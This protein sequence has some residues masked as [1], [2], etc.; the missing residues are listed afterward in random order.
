MV[1]LHFSRTPAITHLKIM[2]LPHRSSHC[3]SVSAYSPPP[4]ELTDPCEYLG[5]KKRKPSY[6]VRK[7]EGKNLKDELLQL[8]AQVAVLKTR[9]MP[10]GS[11]LAADPGLQQSKAKSKA[12]ADSAKQQGLRIA[13]AQS[14]M[15]ECVRA[16]YSNPLCTRICLV[17]DKNERRAVLKAIR[18]EKLKNAYDY[19]MA[20]G[21]HTP[22]GQGKDTS[23]VFQTDNG[24]TCCL[25]STV[26]HF[27]GVRSLKQVFEAIWFYLTNMEISISER[28]GHVAVREDYDMMEGSAYNS[29][30]IATDSNGITTETNTIVFVQFF[31]NGHPQFGGE[32]CAIVA[33]DSVDEDEL[34]PY[35]SSRHIRKDI[36]G[37][38]VMTA[39]KQK[40]QSTG[41]YGGDDEIVVTMRRA[42][43][44]KIHRPEFFIPPLAQQ[45]LEGGI[46]DWGKVMIKTMREV[47]YATM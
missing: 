29:R 46:G 25:G 11:A 45:E 43:Y 16:Q 27:P 31:E 30:I 15:T 33:S 41:E 47:L 13:A 22:E 36:S 3:H 44:L 34:Y 24:D 42:G 19:V 4:D 26:V 2:A 9:G 39:S 32:P 8:Q 28:L 21:S 12:L 5:V 18:A 1:T 40:K 14:L 10:A 37:G 20:C 38:V 6:L 35:Q 7:E 23:K 17:K